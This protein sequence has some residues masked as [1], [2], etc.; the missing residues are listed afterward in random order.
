ME[1][2]DTGDVGRELDMTTAAVR[3]ARLRV[4]Q[5]LRLE[6]GDLLE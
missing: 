6:L 2:R 3:K 1:G 5:R 4:L